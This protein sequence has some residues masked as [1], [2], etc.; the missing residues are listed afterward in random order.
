MPSPYDLVDLADLKSWLDLA[1]TDDDDLLGRLITQVSRAT[2]AFLD[3]AN[4]L[5]ARFVEIRDGRNDIEIVLRQWPVT[6]LAVAH[7]RRRGDCRARRRSLPAARARAAMCSKRRRL[8]RRG[9]CSGWRCVAGCFNAGVQNIDVTYTAG[10]QVS[11]EA[12]VVPS[13]S[14]L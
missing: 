13:S 1:S 4:I 12:A 14:A 5:P 8:R 2:L 9:I 3:R 10:Y 6:S 7:H 11:S